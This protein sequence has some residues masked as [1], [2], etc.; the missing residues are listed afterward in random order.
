MF[1]L[2]NILLEKEIKSRNDVFNLIA[3]EAIL[4]KIILG[5]NRQKLIDAFIN[6]ENE[7]TTGFED[8]F[9]IPHARIKEILKPT[10]FVIRSNTPIK[11]ESMDGNP[12]KVAIA[13]LIPEDQSSTLHMDVLSKVATL[14]LDNEFRKNMHSLKTK[15]KIYNYLNLK[16]NEEKKVINQS[17]TKGLI[18]GVS[19]CAT[20]VAH[21]FMAKDSLEKAGVEMGYKIKIE[22]QGQK[23]IESKLTDTEIEN[24]ESVIIAADIYVDLD[25]FQGKKILKVK[26]NNAI[27]EPVKCIEESLKQNID[28][29]NKSKKTLD[30]NFKQTR[31]NVFMGHLLSGVS[32]MIPF[33]VFSGIVWAIM[34]S[35]GSINGVGDNEVYKILKGISEIGFTVFIAIMGAF[36]AES[37]TGRAGFAPAF[38]AT[39]AAANTNFTFWWNLDGISNPIPQIDFF[40]PNASETGVGNVGL[41]LFSAIIM[42]F[43]A[44]YFI[45]WILS[46]KTHKLITPIISIIFIPVVSTIILTFPFILL[47][48]GPLGFIM[49]AIV[50]GLSEAAKINGL[51]F[52]I[53]FLLG[54]MIGFDMGG[55]INKIAGTCATALIV[56]DP[57]LMGSVAAAIPIA[58]IGC[59][60]S[61]IWARKKFTE[62]ERAEGVSALGLGFFGISEGAIPFAVNR[63]KQ[64]LIAN[65]IASGIAGGLAFLFFCGGYVGMWGGPITAI[66][67]GVSAP[68]TELA[69]LNQTIPQ[70][71]GG[72]SNGLQYISILWFF[73]AIILGSIIHSLIFVF[74]IN[75]SS[76]ED[77]IK[78]DQK[79]ATFRKKISFSLSRKSKFYLN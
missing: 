56:V 19:A 11:W 48:S 67:G 2:E 34:N 61:T 53:G 20:G 45:K 35:L 77:K 28:G 13:L 51:N 12:I 15:E 31:M 6:R 17:G 59:G 79:W 23:G 5:S 46:W 24:A 14:L 29:E 32:R 25:R 74:G 41:S 60:I 57:R 4:L 76:K 58:P 70:I 73:L 39:F 72:G 38:I 78:I 68:V 75:I 1:N 27:S 22:T 63:P 54:C 18:V 55:P 52:L 3:D 66:V 50:F 47:L 64:V 9:A 8:G 33:I 71:F 42:G 21:T 26:T 69:K 65:V 10:I 16:I 37:I 62:K 7:S 49:N 44:G 30:T 43:S 36:I 40:F